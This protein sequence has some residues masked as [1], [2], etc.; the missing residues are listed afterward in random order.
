M[1]ESLGEQVSL[2]GFGEAL[3]GGDEFLTLRNRFFQRLVEAHGYSAITIEI[4]DTT[5]GSSTTISQV[6]ARRLTRRSKT[7]VSAMAPDCMQPI[8]N[9]WSG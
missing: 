5:R 8:A 2:L 7:A 9:S 3:H 1:M 4:T 6:A